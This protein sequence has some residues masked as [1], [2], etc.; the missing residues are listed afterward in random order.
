VNAVSIS[1]RNATA[2]VRRVDVDVVP[3]DHSIRGNAAPELHAVGEAERERALRER[4]G[5]GTSL[6]YTV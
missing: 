3:P 1:W 5:R 2:S 6:P 4:V